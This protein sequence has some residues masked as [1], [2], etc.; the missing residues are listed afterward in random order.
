MAAAKITVVD[1]VR[2]TINPIM[3][4]LSL[5][6]SSS[7]SSDAEVYCGGEGNVGGPGGLV[8]PGGSGGDVGGGGGGDV[9]G[10]GDGNCASSERNPG[11]LLAACLA[12]S[13]DPL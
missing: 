1:V 13:F 7:S 10:G 8:G 5:T 12:D 3:L 2:V 11:V 4:L 9:G 6:A